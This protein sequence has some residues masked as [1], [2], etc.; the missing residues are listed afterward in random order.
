MKYAIYIVFH[1][2]LHEYL[3]EGDEHCY[4]YAKVGDSEA[5]ISSDK[6]RQQVV[7]C[8]DMPGFVPKGKNWAESE[9]LFSLYNTLEKDP[10][11]LRGIEHIGFSQYDHTCIS[12]R[13]SQTVVDFM[14]TKG[15]LI[16]KDTVLSLVPIDFQYEIYGNV[17]AMDFNEPQRQRGNPLCYFTMIADYNKY[18]G[19]AYTYADF[20]GMVGKSISLCSSFVMTRE[21]FMDMMRFSIWASTK[22]NL[23][24]FDPKREY[25]AAGGFM[26]R[27]YG[28]W[29]A[30]SGKKLIEF[31]IEQLTRF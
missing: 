19:T 1:A 27:Y 15:H 5:K 26:E 10:D 2:G 11:Y 14:E 28:T 8:K 23:D 21:N 18:Y 16:D 17:I 9:F 31:P 4:L 6:I 25:R 12:A 20:F 13:H 3:Y 30:L 22:N 24:Q 7:A 29:I